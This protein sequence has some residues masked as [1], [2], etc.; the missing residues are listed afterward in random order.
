MI[1]LQYPV[2]WEEV[3]PYQLNIICSEMLKKLSRED[4][5]SN[6]LFRLLG[7]RP[8]SRP[9]VAE[10]TP[11]ARYYFIY[12]GNTLLLPIWMFR[13]ACE[14]LSFIL[15]TIGMPAECPVPNVHK[16]L[17]GITFEQ[18]YYADAQFLRF[19]E[20]QDRVYLRQVIHTLSPDCRKRVDEN[21]A[22]QFSIWWTGLRAFLKNKYPYVF[23]ESSENNDRTP[24]DTLQDILAFI[25][26]NRPQDNDK[27]LKCEAHAVFNALN[28]KYMEIKRYANKGIS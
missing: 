24:A 6:I 20:T 16:R 25:G 2:M 9:G 14:D 28:N 18:Y 11:D 13:Q 10:G 7:L 1:D 19:K 4:L 17:Y 27:I 12:S 15:D 5:L 23:E 26:D 22:L 8:L 21:Y 3:S